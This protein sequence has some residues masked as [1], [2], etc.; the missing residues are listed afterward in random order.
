MIQEKWHFC[1]WDRL[2]SGYFQ[3]SN[4]CRGNP[5]KVNIVTF[6]ETIFLMR[7]E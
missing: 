1:I 4:L 2:I 5:I 6:S 3:H 7:T